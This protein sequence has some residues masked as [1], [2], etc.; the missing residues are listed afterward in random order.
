MTLIVTDE[1]SGLVRLEKNRGVFVRQISIEEA[2]E[3]YE[4]RAALDEWTGRRL[5]Q[6]ATS[7]QIR[8]LRGYIDRMERAASK[9]DVDAY[10]LLNF[11]FHD[12]LIVLTGNA[13]LLA[14]YRRLVNELSLFRRQ[15]L[16]QG[17]TLPVSTRPGARAATAASWRR[18]RSR[19]A[20]R[21]SFATACGYSASLP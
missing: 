7:E 9:N 4:V 5:A 8:E 17:G 6:R 15:T 1:E 20:R 19:E 21:W 2:D 11:D 13:K 12:R 14:T 3:I 10:W 18:W 16:A